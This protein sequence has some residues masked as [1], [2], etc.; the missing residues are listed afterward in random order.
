[1]K[2]R[3]GNICFIRPLHR[4]QSLFDLRECRWNGYV[5]AVNSVSSPFL[6]LP[7]LSLLSSHSFAWPHCLHMYNWWVLYNRLAFA[8]VSCPLFH[9]AAVLVARMFLSFLLFSLTT[10]RE[11]RHSFVSV[12]IRMKYRHEFHFSAELVARIIV[13]TQQLCV[14]ASPM[15]LVSNNKKLSCY[16]LFQISSL[17]RST[18]PAM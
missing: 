9:I 3:C 10:D 16:C 14:W 8:L 17:L 1:M 2:V 18:I 13:H 5:F 12:Y 11:H 7:R 15:S 4:S 6:P